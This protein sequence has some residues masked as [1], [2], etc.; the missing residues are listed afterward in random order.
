M[1]T[2]GMVDRSRAEPDWDT[3]WSVLDLKHE[4]RRLGSR[5]ELLDRRVDLLDHRIEKRLLVLDNAVATLRV[6]SFALLSAV[7]IATLVGL[8]VLLLSRR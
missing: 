4:I 6:L 2:G 1:E 5:V 8:F 3:R 7:G